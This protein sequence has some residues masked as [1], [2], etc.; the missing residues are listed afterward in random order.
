MLEEK[1]EHYFADDQDIELYPDEHFTLEHAKETFEDCA[2]AVTEER[3][4]YFSTDHWDLARQS[5]MFFRR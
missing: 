3:Q 5:N 1:V 2:R 4:E